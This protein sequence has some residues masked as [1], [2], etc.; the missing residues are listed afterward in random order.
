ME[1]LSLL[2]TMSDTEIEK[3]FSLSRCTAYR[4]RHRL[5]IAPY[6]RSLEERFWDKIDKSDNTEKCW[7]WIGHKNRKGYGVF[8]RDGSARIATRTLM[9]LITGSPVPKHI[10]VCH[11]CDNPSCCN[12]KHLFLGTAGENLADSIA[13]GRF[14]AREYWLRRKPIVLSHCRNGH[15]FTP[16]N[17]GVDKYSRYC[18]ICRKANQQRKNAVQK[19]KRNSKCPSP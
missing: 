2:G 10:Q 14:K 9:E 15:E 19:Q 3:L 6:K 5:G 4:A 17:I 16:D 11:H 8:L 13:K 18:I 7:P 12:P 1:Y